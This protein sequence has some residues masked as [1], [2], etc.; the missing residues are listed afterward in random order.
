VKIKSN[1]NKNL[2]PALAA[3]GGGL[4]AL[5]VHAIEL[6]E[7]QV[8]STL[9]QP[10][11]A[12]IA[13]ALGPSE[14]LYD[15]CISL[16]QGQ[17]GN[18]LPSVRQASVSVANGVISL[19]GRSP[20][21]EPLI[22][23]RVIV[24][25]PYTAHISREYMMF[26]DPPGAV[27]QP[28]ATPVASVPQP[29]ARPQPVVEQGPTTAVQR[30]PLDNASRYRVLPGDTLSGIAQ[31]IENRPVG[32]WDAVNAIY[33]ANPDAFIDS[34]MNK[35]KA[36]SWLEIPDFGA[37]LPLTVADETVV[38]PAEAP[39]VVVTAED[40]AAYEP[41]SALPPDADPLAVE[42]P[43]DGVA[44][45]SAA[46]VAEPAVVAAAQVE[47]GTGK[48]RDALQPGDIIL[49]TDLEAPAITAESPNQATATISQPAAPVDSRSSY[50]WLLWLGGASF[51][52]LLGLFMFARRGRGSFGSTPVGPIAEQPMRRSTDVAPTQELEPLVD[53][54]YDLDDDS[55][56]AENLALDAD[57]VIGTGLGNGVDVE[58]AEDFAFATGA[59][60]DFELPE[61]MS[62]N[63]GQHSTDI[64]PPVSIEDSS[65]LVS[66][67]FPD[68]A[69][70]ED[71]FDMS[72]VVDATKMPHPE[73][74][75]ERDL[76]AVV[77]EDLDDE[78]L[79]DSSYTI[80]QES[81]F[82][83]LE[84]DYEDN[85][86]ATQKLSAELARAS[87]ELTDN[88]RSL[89][90]DDSTEEMPLATVTELDVTAQLP[91]RNDDDVD[92][93]D[94][95]GVSEEITVNME[96]EDKTVEMEVESGKVDT[97]TG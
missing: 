28:V 83:I 65:I 81:D 38:A 78:T 41:A 88:L 49:D 14:S 27:M 90:G 18:G 68:E 43:R 51:A 17:Q 50:T 29:A 93:P 96:A 82:H 35:L 48:T 21:R 46:D 4:A 9:G 72:V 71:D 80:S 42:A 8:H 32:L 23:A 47:P 75:T 45:T 74:T 63:T 73:E 5:P 2:F 79:I 3:I 52:L 61:E 94:G 44:A 19:T 24:D 13:Y 39:Q 57:L 92:D 40:S 91:A 15:F 16:S 37:G 97:K 64:I 1:Q 12:S 54:D 60:P 20:V 59:A 89:G 85:F 33:A 22:T 36:G 55:P 53:E 11:R 67:V 30:P 10:L 62:S 31:R 87:E 77:I 69:A 66:E 84:Q 56:T 25:C 95:T 34:D 26:V 7:I 70:D 76:K 58:V 6:G 86:T